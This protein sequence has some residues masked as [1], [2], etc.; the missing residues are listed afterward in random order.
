MGFFRIVRRPVLVRAI[1]PI[2][3]AILIALLPAPA[4]LA[5]HAWR[6]S[7]IFAG[8]I[9]GLVLT[10]LPGAA[11]GFLGVTAVTVL[12]PFVLYSPEQLAQPDFRAAPAAIAWALSGF[13]DSTVWLIFGAYMFALGYEKTGLGRRIAL[14]LVKWMGGRT[15]TLGYAIA[16]ADLAL[17]PFTPSNTARSGGVIYPVVRH[18]P[19]LYGSAPNDPSARRIGSYLMWVAVAAVSITGSTF[20]TGLAPNLLALEFAR[21]A[22]HVEFTWTDWFIA[23]APVGAVLLALTPALAYWIYPPGVKKGDEA[24]AWAARELAE[25]GGLTRNEV[26][27]GL[28][29]VLGL[30]LWIFA[31]SYVNATTVA[32][33]VVSLMLVTGVF[34]WSDVA[35]NGQAWSTLAWFATLVALANGLSS[36]GFIKWFAAGVVLRLGGLSPGAAMIALLAVFF[37]AHYL[38]ASLTAH[39]TALMPVMLAAGASIPGLPVPQFAMLLCLEL[40]IMGILTPYA[41]GPS[42]I[43]QSSGYLPPADYWR[44]GLIFGCVFFLVLIAVGVPWTTFVFRTAF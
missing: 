27:L 17:A 24:P 14:L 23:A 38:F 10:P 28:L 4:G 25:A 22:L 3:L 29:V 33:V 1:A 18:L 19:K 5:L 31:G 39:T 16:L 44:L 26:I 13:S 42:P 11:I 2:A 34:T 7:A 37:F 30:G 20:L 41:T 15:L 8:V 40:G 9:L 43:Y 21:K 35:A 32:L 36:V 12:A 6:Y